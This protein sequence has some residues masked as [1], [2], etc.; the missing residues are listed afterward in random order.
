MY[1]KAYEL[2]NAILGSDVYKRFINARESLK[3]MKIYV[4]KLMNTGIK[5]LLYR[6]ALRTTE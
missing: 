6:I 3:S 4:Q 2:S 5:I 1:E